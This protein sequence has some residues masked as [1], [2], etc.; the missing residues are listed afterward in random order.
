MRDDRNLKLHCTPMTASLTVLVDGGVDGGLGSYRGVWIAHRRAVPR[1][2]LS[3]I[4]QI[5]ALPGGPTLPSS[6]RNSRR[7]AGKL[8]VRKSKLLKIAAAAL[9]VM[10]NV[11][12]E[13][14]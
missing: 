14:G 6:Q 1:R 3:R 11:C 9:S 2:N 7:D 4:E 13:L 12:C 10:R 5:N 8:A